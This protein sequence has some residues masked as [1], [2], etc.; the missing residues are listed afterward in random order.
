MVASVDEYLAKYAAYDAALRSLRQAASNLRTAS[1]K[2]WSDFA[3]WSVDRLKGRNDVAKLPE[4][5][6]VEE[7]RIAYLQYVT[8]RKTVSEAYDLVP[9]ELRTGLKTILEAPTQQPESWLE[10]KLSEMKDETA[11]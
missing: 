3:P 5:P 7:Y 2:V 10:R 6:S 9:E 11:R 4:W 8:H 1:Q